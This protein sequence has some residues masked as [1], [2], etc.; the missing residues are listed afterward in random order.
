[1]NKRRILALAMVVALVSG[2]VGG[3]LPGAGTTSTP[4]GN[5]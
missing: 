2:L 5:T 4:T 3:W 1:M